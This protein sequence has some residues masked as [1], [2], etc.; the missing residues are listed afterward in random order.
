MIGIKY[1][2]PIQ[3]FDVLID[4]EPDSSMI[5]CQDKEKDENCLL[6]L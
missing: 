5:L 3:V 2:K 6:R 1:N 4:S